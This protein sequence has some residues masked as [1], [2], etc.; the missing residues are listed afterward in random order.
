M[1][2][3]AGEPSGAGRRFAVVASRFNEQITQKL[4]DGA[5]D[6]LTRHGASFD[7]V[8]LVW[9]PGAWELPAAARR[10]LASDRYDAIIAVGAVIRG[11]TPHFDYVAGEA[12]RGLAD[13][14]T[15]FDR[16][17]GFGLLTCDTMEQAEARA[18]GAHGNKGWDAAMA[19]LEMADLF[20]RL[21]VDAGDDE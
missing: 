4:A 12:S 13:A 16:P 6:A 2:E 17:I 1:A 8:D 14:S 10:L 7:D 9:V 21:D 18:G 15:E 5:L 11:D 19:A 20:D 3:F